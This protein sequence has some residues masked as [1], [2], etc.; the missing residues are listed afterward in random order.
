MT[1]LYVKAGSFSPMRWPFTDPAT[2][3]PLD[4]TAPGYS[5]SGTV[6]TTNDSA[7]VLLLELVDDEVWARTAD[8]WV[9][10]Q[11]PSVVSSEWPA[12]AAWYQAYLH[13]PSGQK[14][15]FDED[16]FIIDTDFSS[17]D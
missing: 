16:R 14:V 1:N 2:G 15:R 10:F 12:V 13:H 4:L 9:Y 7:G 3:A 8:G 11:P 6:R 17:E 5:V